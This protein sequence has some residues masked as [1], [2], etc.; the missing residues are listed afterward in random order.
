MP[1]TRTAPTLFV[2]VLRIPGDATGAAR[3][4]GES[5]GADLL[6]H[7]FTSG[8]LF[9]LRRQQVPEARIGDDVYLGAHQF[10]SED[11]VSAEVKAG[12]GE[13]RTPSS[14]SIVTQAVYTKLAD[15]GQP[16]PH[17]AAGPRS[18]MVVFSHATDPAH[19]ALFNAWYTENH[20]I[21]VGKSPHF[22]SA[23]RYRLRLQGAGAPLPYLCIY[24]IDHAYTDE[25]FDWMMGWLRDTPDDFRQPMPMTPGGAPVLTLDLWGYYER[26]WGAA[27]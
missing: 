14:A 27:S 2:E 16:N 23:T 8:S 24:E 6:R 17:G 21:D 26:V 22:R 5:R 12:M 25:L 15:Y 4:Y 3:A 20:M 18:A 7:G 13:R 11:A 10:A 1:E 19:D 9:H